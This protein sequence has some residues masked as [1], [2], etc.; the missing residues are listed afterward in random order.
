MFLEVS[1]KD[2]LKEI[3][4]NNDEIPIAQEYLNYEQYRHNY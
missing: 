4:A 1:N 2:I 3:Y